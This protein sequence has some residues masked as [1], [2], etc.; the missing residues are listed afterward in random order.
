MLP[1]RVIL[2]I[3]YMDKSFK[4]TEILSKKVAVVISRKWLTLED[5][6]DSKG[7]SFHFMHGEKKV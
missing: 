6:T 4:M 2:A 1:T 3:D 7:L 5:D